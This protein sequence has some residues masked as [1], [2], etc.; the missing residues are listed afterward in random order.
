MVT[1]M[2]NTSSVSLRQE[3]IKIVVNSKIE[4]LNNNLI[5]IF[6]YLVQYDESHTFDFAAYIRNK[7]NVIYKILILI[8]KEDMFSTEL[9]PFL[10]GFK[11]KNNHES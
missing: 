4:S 3:K 5:S 10:L 9:K 2:S 7:S 6:L 11:P 1:L 8:L